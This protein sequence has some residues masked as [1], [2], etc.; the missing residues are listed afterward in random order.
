MI[1]IISIS[2]TI[3]SRTILEISSSGWIHSTNEF[4]DLSFI[5][6][7]FLSICLSL[8]QTIHPQFL[9]LLLP[10]S[11]FTSRNH[12]KQSNG[13]DGNSSSFQSSSSSSIYK[14]I[15]KSSLSDR[16][17]ECIQRTSTIFQT[18]KHLECNHWKP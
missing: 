5:F 10:I 4:T 12:S 18:F 11:Q 8:S 16:K 9:P 2:S 7:S 13:N 1:C 17:G 6:E 3:S 15:C 14:Q